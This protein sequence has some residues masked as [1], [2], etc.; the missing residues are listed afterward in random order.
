[1]S[2]NKHALTIIFLMVAIITIPVHAQTLEPTQETLIELKKIIQDGAENYIEG[3][4]LK[5]LQNIESSKFDNVYRATKSIVVNISGG[6]S[7]AEYGPLIRPLVSEIAL[8]EDMKLT[9]DELFLLDAYKLAS[10]VYSK[11]GIFWSQAIQNNSRSNYN[12]EEGQQLMKQAL[13][14]FWG[15]AN[16][17]VHNANETYI[18][19]KK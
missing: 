8:L 12:V 14:V 6:I 4:S 15:V 19:N 3:D 2:I 13:N 18:R 1:M 5:K 17:I 11:T 16:T 9:N 10:Q 7:Y